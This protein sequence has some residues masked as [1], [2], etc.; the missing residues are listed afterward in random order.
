MYGERCGT[1]LY[2]GTL[3]CIYRRA[4]RIGSTFATFKY[5]IGLKMCRFNISIGLYFLDINGAY[6]YKTTM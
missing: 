6:F 4:A 3:C 1:F 5:M 2:T